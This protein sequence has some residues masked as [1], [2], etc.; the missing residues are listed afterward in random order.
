MA[1]PLVDTAGTPGITMQNGWISQFHQTWVTKLHIKP[2][3]S[4]SRL[5]FNNVST[6]S[7]VKISSYMKAI[8]AIHVFPRLPSHPQVEKIDFRS[9]QSAGSLV[10]IWIK[11]NLFWQKH[12]FITSWVLQVYSYNGVYICYTYM[13]A[14]NRTCAHL[15]V[16]SSRGIAPEQEKLEGF[17]LGLPLFRGLCQICWRN[18]QTLQLLKTPSSRPLKTRI[19]TKHEGLEL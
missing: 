2:V 6:E 8:Q 12:W 10:D 17:F 4:T 11:A 15:L 18:Y 3:Y 5:D 1:Y 9:Y 13:Y 19:N 16:V 7:A 14:I